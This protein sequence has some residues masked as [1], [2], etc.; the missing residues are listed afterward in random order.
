MTDDQQRR[1]E[2]PGPADQPDQPDQPG[3]EQPGTAWTPP[4]RPPVGPD[5]PIAD[6]PTVGWTPPE[7]PTP[8]WTPPPPN[9][10]PPPYSTGSGPLLSAT[11]TPTTGWAQAPD[12]RREVA[13]GL[14]FSSTTARFAAFV[15]D[16]FLLALVS[17]LFTSTI[18]SGAAFNPSGGLVW[19]TGDFVASIL[20]TVING[21]YF[22][23]FWSGGRRATLGQMLFKI[24]V[25]NAFDGR[26]LTLEQAV[27]RWL[28]LGQFLG[29]FAISAAAIGFIGVLS[30]IWTVALF[31]TT[32]SSP[33]KQGLHDR[34]ANSAVVRPVNAGN[35][36]VYTCLIVVFAVPILA[37]LAVLS[38]LI[39]G[40]QVSDMLST[41]GTSVTAP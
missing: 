2:Q 15:T 38:L 41:I 36:L 1:P 31:F 37:V 9:E 25:G 20:T 32:I 18:G 30:L 17:G 22:V 8:A 26:P 28:G 39:V 27:R 3:V 19:T 21:A 23:A 6:Q 13:P 4:Q 14:V 12:T 33:T 7:Q 40:T 5:E 16:S 35:G 24:Q 29:V 34:F 11:P 10:P